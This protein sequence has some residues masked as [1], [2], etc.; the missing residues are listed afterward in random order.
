MD[1]DE[2]KRESAEW[3]AAG[4]PISSGECHNVHYRL[5]IYTQNDSGFPLETFSALKVWISAMA[6]TTTASCLS[7]N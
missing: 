3:V 4:V 5:T 7:L 2:Y 6:H 1:W